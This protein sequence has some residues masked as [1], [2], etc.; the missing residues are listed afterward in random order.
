MWDEKIYPVFV[1]IIINHKPRIPGSVL[2]NQHS[3]ERNARFFDHGENLVQDKVSDSKPRRF[4]P[5]PTIATGHI[6]PPKTEMYGKKVIQLCLQTEKNSTV[7]NL[8]IW[9]CKWLRGDLFYGSFTGPKCFFRHGNT[10]FSTK[11]W[12]FF[13]HA[14]G[15]RRWSLRAF[16][17][18]DRNQVFFL[19]GFRISS[20]I[21]VGG[22]V[23]PI[24]TLNY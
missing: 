24:A 14:L 2:N 17:Q 19:S 10:P 16:A 6:S 23:S 5:G 22:E 13:R 7:S 18:T 21:Q 12:H 4:A 1:G 9:F 11:C 8:T 20:S 3:T 15:P